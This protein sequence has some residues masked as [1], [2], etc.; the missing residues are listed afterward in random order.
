MSRK[1]KTPMDTQTS[2]DAVPAAS[3]RLH[4]ADRAGL[5][6]DGW[7][8]VPEDLIG[9]PDDSNVPAEFYEPAS[10]T[11]PPDQPL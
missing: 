2:R 8:E 7:A 5:G 6:D 1:P 4:G 10:E 3:D 9:D 11:N